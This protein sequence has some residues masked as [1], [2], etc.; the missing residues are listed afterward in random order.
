MLNSQYANV[1]AGSNPASSVTLN[2]VVSA[3]WNQNIFVQP[4]ITVA[5][6][7]IAESVGNPS[8]VTTDSSGNIYLSGTYINM[9]GTT[10][11]G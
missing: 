9:Y 8:G 7:G 3:E 4:Y 6:N 5:G 11:N 1:F 10:Y 2:P